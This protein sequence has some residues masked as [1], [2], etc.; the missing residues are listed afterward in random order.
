MNL[1]MDEAKVK[2][3]RLANCGLWMKSDLRIIKT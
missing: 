2:C 1:H 3:H